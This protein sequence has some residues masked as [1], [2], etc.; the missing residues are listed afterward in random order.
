MHPA[1]KWAEVFDSWRVIP[2]LVLFAYGAFVY[3]VTFFILVWYTNEPA[4]ARGTEES[5][6]II[7]VFTA[8]AGFAS[9]VFKVYS[10]SGRDW[11]QA[12][13]DRDASPSA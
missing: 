9:W 12:P 11:N 10:E 1:L 3:K 7:G 8:I 13:R 6:V 5:A 4:T 2:R